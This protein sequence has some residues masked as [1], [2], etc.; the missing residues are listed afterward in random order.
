MPDTPQATGRRRDAMLTS[1]LSPT[2][3]RKLP[4]LAWLILL[5]K[6]KLSKLPAEP[7]ADVKMGFH[8]LKNFMCHRHMEVKLSPQIN[9]IIGHN[10]SELDGISLRNAYPGP[11]LCFAPIGGKS[12][13]LTAITYAFG[14]KASASVSGH[15]SRS[16][17]NSHL[18]I[19]FQNAEPWHIAEQFHPHRR[20]FMRGYFRSSK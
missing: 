3:D 15:Y 18:I 17:A 20:P 5:C 12:V 14:A 11:I 1:G 8:S 19:G 13:I 2:F 4:R 16:F 7:A 9:F 10:G 6:N